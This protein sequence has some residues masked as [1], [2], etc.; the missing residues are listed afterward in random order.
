MRLGSAL[1]WA[2][3]LWLGAVL[4][5]MATDAPT[6]KQV[7]AQNKL[8]HVRAQIKALVAKQHATDSQR[9]ALQAGLTKQAE[10]LADAAKAVSAASQA[11]AEQRAALTK[12]ETQRASLQA[13]LQQQRAALADLLRATYALGHGNDLRMLL[14]QWSRCDAAHAASTA[15]SADADSC[16][17]G[18]QALARID[19]ALAY[20]R[21]FQHDRIQRI[22]AL[23]TKLNQLHQVEA[24]IHTEQAA[25]QTTL[26]ARRARV[27]SLQQQRAAQATLLAQAEAQRQ[28]QGKQLKSLQQDERSVQ[29][30]IARLRD[31]FADLPRTLPG[32]TPFA[33]LRGK[34]H[35]PLHGH[36]RT[37]NQGVLISS[38]AGSAVRAVAHGRVVYADWLRGYGML[39]IIDQGDGWMS[40]YGGNEVLLR[41]VGDWVDAGAEIATSGQGE[42]GHPGLYFG[43][44]HHGQ[45]VNPRPWL[46]RKP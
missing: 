23:L 4:P 34:L 45:A 13:G 40:L 7:A 36:M 19:R 46:T 12:L 2:C 37:H 28:Q 16:R 30:L 24:A 17:S 18:A 27:A 11:V 33:Q 42:A 43:L 21:Y 29:A 20:S 10:K 6:P 5:S 1:A 26:D 15:P 31:V 38:H 41:E 9:H 8:E 39:L 22:Q 44:R 14:G 35:W 25:L 3:A 32:E